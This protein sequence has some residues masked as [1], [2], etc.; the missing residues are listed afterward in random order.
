MRKS[1][2]SDVRAEL[3]KRISSSFLTSRTVT[4]P[5]LALSLILVAGVALPS[6]LCLTQQRLTITTTGQGVVDSSTSLLSHDLLLFESILGCF[7]VCPFFRLDLAL[8]G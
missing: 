1:T 7:R 8:V 3:A 6:F 5:A 2:S 4:H